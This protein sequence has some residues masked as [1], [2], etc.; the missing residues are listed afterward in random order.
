MTKVIAVTYNQ[1]RSSVVAVHNNQVVGG[2]LT[3][4]ALFP[5][6][7]FI[8]LSDP[9]VAF[10]YAV[11]TSNRSYADFKLRL[12]TVSKAEPV[13]VDYREAMAMSSIVMRDWDSCA[14]MVVDSTHCALGYYSAGKF[15]WIRE[16]IYPNS[17]SL[18]YSAAARLLGFDPAT[19][20]HLLTECSEH[21]QPA[22]ASLIEQHFI[23]VTEDG[24]ALLQNLEQGVGRG[25]LNL[26]IA[27][28][29]QAVFTKTILALASWLSKQVNNTCLAYAGRASAN[30]RTNTALATSG[31]FEQLSIQPLTSAA[32]A[33][34]GAA[35]LLSRP[36]WDRID[37]GAMSSNNYNP[38]IIAAQLL[39]GQVVR[40]DNGRQEFIDRSTINRNWLAIPYKPIIE[41]F[42]R[43][44]LLTYSW[45]Q[46]FI[47]CQEKDYA[48]YYDTPF[49]PQ[50]GQFASTSQA[51]PLITIPSN[52][53]VVTTN[54][55]RN[56]FINRVLEIL[57]AEG[58]P[59]LISSPIESV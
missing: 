16:F 28:S 50:Y 9:H 8:E 46:P 57:R 49:T 37:I 40:Y 25:P 56:P 34:I 26:D 51:N 11:T 23:N 47:V 3:S 32:G 14:V 18:F 43:K 7:E 54:L 41:Q 24:Y 53:K 55:N 15:H 45:Q 13:L 12:K 30:Y 6:A 29:V 35:S 58:Y 27:S 20:E 39:Q 38:D 22:Y 42:R 33:A 5:A 4:T 2:L 52:S 10:D 44:A 31:Y 19:Q 59:M 21:G 48:T 1:D 17:I 36:I